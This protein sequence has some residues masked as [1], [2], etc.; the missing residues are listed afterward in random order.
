MMPRRDRRNVSIFFSL[1][2][3]SLLAADVA[4]QSGRSD[5]VAFAFD[6]ESVVQWK[7][8]NRLSEISGLTTTPDDRVWAHNDELG[9]IYQLDP[10]DGEIGKIFAFGDSTVKGD[11]EG[12]AF[13]EDR[14]YLVDSGGRIYEG[15]EG[16]HDERVLYNTYETRVGRSCEVEGLEFDPVDRALLLLCKRSKVKELEGYVGI[17]RW[18]LD[19]R[20]LM[21]N[22]VL[23]PM[24]PLAGG[25]DQKSFNPSGL[26]RNPSTGTYF[27]IAAR[28]RGIAEI[29]LAGEVLAVRRLP[30][31]LHRQAEGITFTSNS[32]LLIADE[33]AG[34]RSRLTIYRP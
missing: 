11:F 19:A 22:P 8:H 34:K 21:P 9:I 3:A 24:D 7:L 10:S 15:R 20:A 29:T 30:K 28:Q 13:A 26:A 14:F 16:A 2:V 23:V 31:D 33:G 27:M 17:F 18:S 6:A 4:A 12:I 25:V 5:L 1:Q 32:M